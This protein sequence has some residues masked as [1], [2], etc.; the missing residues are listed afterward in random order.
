[1]Y[2]RTEQNLRGGRWLSSGIENT[3]PPTAVHHLAGGVGFLP[4]PRLGA[5][6]SRVG[7]AWFDVTGVKQS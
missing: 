4:L 6:H 5:I 3:F 7:M 2:V 1:M